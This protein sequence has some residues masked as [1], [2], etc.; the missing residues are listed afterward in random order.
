MENRSLY[1]P[2]QD[3]YLSSFNA[4]IPEI[5]INEIIELKQVHIVY[6]VVRR[7]GGGRNESARLPTAPTQGGDVFFANY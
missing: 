4:L 7:D 1:S 6:A 2:A 5:S 3:N